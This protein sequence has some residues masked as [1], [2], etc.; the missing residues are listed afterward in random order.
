MINIRRAEATELLKINKKIFN[1]IDK[2]CD[3]FDKE[4]VL[5]EGDK[6]NEIILDLLNIPREDKKRG[7]KDQVYCIIYNFIL[8]NNDYTAE[9][10]IDMLLSLK[11]G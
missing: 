9:E 7:I 4:T 8:E 1:E 11:E 2:F 6:I 5:Q 10:V 3:N